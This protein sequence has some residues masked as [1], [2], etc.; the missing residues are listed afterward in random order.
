MVNAWA[1]CC[2]WTLGSF[3]ALLGFGLGC[4]SSDTDSGTGGTSATSGGGPGSGGAGGSALAACRFKLDDPLSPCEATFA[5]HSARS[6]SSLVTP[7]AGLFSRVDAV[8]GGRMLECVFDQNGNLVAWSIAENTKAF[9]DGQT[10]VAVAD[11]LSR[12]QLQGC[13][14][15][16][17]GWEWI[18]TFDASP[19]TI[20]VTVHADTKSEA[21]AIYPS[22]SFVLGGTEIKGSELSLRYWYTSEGSSPSE[23]TPVCDST[24]GLDCSDLVMTLFSVTPPRTGADA[25][26]EVSF[27][28]YSS[29][30]GTG[31]PFRLLFGITK[32]DGTPY[33][34]SNDYSHADA[35]A[36][37]P[38]TKVT[39]YLNGAL[40]YGRE[41]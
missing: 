14:Y 18:E 20:T 29:V 40:Y 38:T 34:Q 1:R 35:S 11:L 28:K 13:F 27:P 30:L 26:L 9:C 10:S 41:P 3:G 39:A 19:T 21:H 12:G 16:D 23:Q 6:P 8:A 31:F 25:Y 15:K 22:L 2:E 4:S 33:D 5:E 36:S 24:N 17:D 37:V 7:C 32:S